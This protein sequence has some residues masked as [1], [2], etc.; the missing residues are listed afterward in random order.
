MT[1]A[2]QHRRSQ[3]QR[4][5]YRS[6][7]PV[8]VMPSTLTCST[9]SRLYL[10]KSLVNPSLNQLQWDALRLFLDVPADDKEAGAE[11][12]SINQRFGIAYSW[13]RIALT[14]VL[15]STFIL[16]SSTQHSQSRIPNHRSLS[17]FKSVPFDLYFLLPS[18]PEYYC[19]ER[20]TAHFM[21]NLLYIL[22]L[23]KPHYCHVTGDIFHMLPL[24]T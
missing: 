7:P 12:V 17:P 13:F 24:V 9:H 14:F 4:H 1:A 22:L 16:A 10:D 5:G 6:P 3:D 11:L 21:F 15:S 8:L 2:Q 19:S 18:H 20:N 23:R